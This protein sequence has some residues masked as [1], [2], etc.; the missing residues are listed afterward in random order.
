[1]KIERLFLL[2][3]GFILLILCTI[4][5][6]TDDTLIVKGEIVSLKYIDNGA[7]VYLRTDKGIEKVLVPSYMMDRIESTSIGDKIIIHGSIIHFK[8]DK[9]IRAEEIDK[10]E[11]YNQ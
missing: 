3:F 7:I 10:M 2:S 9:E 5:V 8:G 1:M 11:I 6:L 4:Y